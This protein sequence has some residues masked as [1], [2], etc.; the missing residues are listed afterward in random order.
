MEIFGNAR[1]IADFLIEEEGL[2]HAMDT[3]FDGI[4]RAHA[5]HD[6][7]LLSV[8]REVRNILRER[9]KVADSGNPPEDDT[10]AAE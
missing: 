6:Y 3:A 10:I 9:R 2:D 7:Y 1:E 4:A 8:W 5:E